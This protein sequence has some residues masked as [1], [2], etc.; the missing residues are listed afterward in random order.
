[1]RIL[2][3]RHGD[4]DYENDTLTPKGHREAK[5]LS[6]I[7][8]DLDIGDCY[9]SPLGR[10]RDTA[11]YSL[12][13]L[14]KTAPILDW[15]QEFP[16]KV[17]LNLAPELK[18]AY[19]DVKMDGDGYRPRI[20][21][22]MLPG[23]LS[24]HPEYTDPHRWK[25]SLVAQNGDLNQVYT[26]VVTQFDS[27]LADYGYIRKD[28]YYAVEK[29][30]TKTITF[31]CHFGITCLLLSRLWNIS[32]F[33]L[34]HSLALAPSSVTEVV[35]E[36]RS[37]GIAYFRGLRLGD[38]SHLTLGGEMPSFSARFCETYENMEQRH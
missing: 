35:T 19:P 25:E 4:P 31:F 14:G 24:A 16:A 12:E 32:P 29:G 33:L 28:G 7:I 38:V 3:I 36:E 37:K 2:F 10:A 13:K 18:A 22:D 6:D 5:L 8:Q 9:V 27:L 20:V 21:W 26:S 23:Y 30:H 11:R 15:L 1:M 17:N 34:W